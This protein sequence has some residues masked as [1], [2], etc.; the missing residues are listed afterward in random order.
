MSLSCPDLIRASINLR[1]NLFS[2]MMD[3][4]VKPG[5]D[6]L[7]PVSFRS[8]EKLSMSYTGK[9]PLISGMKKMAR[10]MAKPMFHR[11]DLSLGRLPR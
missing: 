8:F 9:T 1:N 2:K 3:H 5:D 10:L 11:I 6:D 4:R 7:Q